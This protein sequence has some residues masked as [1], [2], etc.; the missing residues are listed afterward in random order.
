MILALPLVTSRQFL[1]RLRPQTDRPPMR[2]D[3]WLTVCSLHDRACGRPGQ[4]TLSLRRPVVFPAC[5]ASVA[6][7][8]SSRGTRGL[9]TSRTTACDEQPLPAARATRLLHHACASRA[10]DPAAPAPPD[11]QTQQPAAAE[12]SVRRCQYM[13]TAPYP[14]V[15]E[16]AARGCRD[17]IACRPECRQVGM[18]Q[19]TQ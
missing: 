2:P 15:P 11:G 16:L 9:R 12:V 17:R 3:I 1:F 14:E 6:A 10:H 4:S 7:Q 13:F 5:A 18:R 19:C 8:A